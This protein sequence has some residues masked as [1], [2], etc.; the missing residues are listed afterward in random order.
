MWL[1]RHPLNNSLVVFIHGIFGS[2]W[3][4][5][6]SYVDFFQLL[7]YEQPLLRSYDIFL[8]EYQTRGLRQLRLDPDVVM[9]LRQ[10]LAD[11]QQREK[12]ETIVLVCHSQ[13]GILGKLYILHELMKG[14]GAEL[15][16]DMIITLCT[17][18]RGIAWLN[19]LWKLKN[20]PWFRDW[21]MLRQLSDL[22]SKSSNIQFL[23]RHWGDHWISPK[24]CPAAPKRRYIR[25]IAITG[26]KDFLVSEASARG[27]NV[28]VKDTMVSGHSVDSE[29]VI[30]YVARSYLK[31]HLDPYEL[32]KQLN[33]TKRA[34]CQKELCL[35]A[36]GEIALHRR[37]AVADYRRH[38][39]FC[40]VEDFW[41]IFPR[42]PMRN[43]DLQA[44]FVAYVKRSLLD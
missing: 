12:Y 3:T 31:E 1:S 32:E 2:R 22:A 16:V 23:S 11:P 37:A 42:H 29:K 27:F 5:W 28:D 38:R 18:H 17:P 13:G 35:A 39:P 30:N 40:F 6:R 10:F 21:K 41:D 33:A 15:R 26:L 36:T 24:A 34:Q 7:P 44:A 8:F 43:L 25:S 20:M 4:T 9:H 19:P 14:R